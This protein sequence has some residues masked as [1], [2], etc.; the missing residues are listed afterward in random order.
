MVG[1]R[2]REVIPAF[3]NDPEAAT[4]S[5]AACGLGDASLLRKNQAGFLSSTHCSADEFI[6]GL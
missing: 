3:D 4:F 6:S 5:A 2:S 1:M